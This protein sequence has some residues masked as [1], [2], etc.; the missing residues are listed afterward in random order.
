MEIVTFLYLARCT[1]SG[2]YG[3][4]GLHHHFY[5]EDG[6][7]FFLQAVT[8]LRPNPAAASAED[9]SQV[10]ASLYLV[11]SFHNNQN[12]SDNL[13]GKGNIMQQNHPKKLF[14]K[15]SADFFFSFDD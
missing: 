3:L 8:F 13:K 2:T 14:W 11:V 7:I 10:N 15:V 9:C 4:V 1:Y 5:L 6:S 12:Y